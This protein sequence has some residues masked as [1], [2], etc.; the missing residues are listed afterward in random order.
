[1]TKPE[2]K[3]AAVSLRKT[4]LSYSEIHNELGVAKST[5]SYWLRDVDLPPVA[6]A[7]LEH[8]ERTAQ[9]KS[10]LKAAAKN[11]L[12][13]Q[14]RRK[15]LLE[16][17]RTCYADVELSPD[18]LALV[19]AALYWAEG[20]KGRNS[21]SFANSDPQMIELYIKWLTEILDI[22]KTDLVF[23]ISV[24]LDCGLSYE[25]VVSWWSGLIGVPRAQFRPRRAPD[26]RPKKKKVKPEKKLRYGILHIYVRNPQQHRA[27]YFALGEKLGVDSS[28]FPDIG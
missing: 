27:A 22:P 15:R 17:K 12:I 2:L 13:H 5:L 8:R 23:S 10:C 9:K 21:F 14:N 26:P 25:E 16:E 11:K 19:G 20:S 4:G 18:S 3:A 1:M 28:V 6:K 7:R 24:Y